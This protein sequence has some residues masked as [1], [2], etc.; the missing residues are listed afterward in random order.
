MTN[1]F[2]KA[3]EYKINIQKS[4]IFLYT[5]NEILEKEYKN[6]M[7]FKIAAQKFK[8]LGIYLNKEV[9]C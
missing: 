8:Y 7:P 2:N 1:K 3:A 9:K 5:N 4:V 6:K